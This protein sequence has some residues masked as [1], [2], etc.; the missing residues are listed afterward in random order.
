MEIRIQSEP[1]DPGAELTAFSAAQTGAG[2]IVS[3]SGVVRD[4][5]G[6]LERLE[7]EHYPGMTE[8]ALTQICEE[9]GSRWALTG[10]TV[11]HRY[12]PMAVGEPIMMVMTAS[13]HRAEAFQ[14]AE[15]LMDYLKSRAPFWKKEHRG[16][17]SSWVDAREADEAALKRWD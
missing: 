12:G 6:D 13:A 9:A 8:R 2:A 11:I 14:A 3:F 15:F 17:D 5:E 1:F 7:L 4:L 10:T 16:S